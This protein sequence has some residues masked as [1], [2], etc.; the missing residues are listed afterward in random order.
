MTEIMD[1]KCGCT[2][3]R[4]IK[5]LPNEKFSSIDYF[6]TPLYSF[7]GFIKAFG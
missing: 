1:R 5:N 6:V 3:N 7:N 4:G 2:K